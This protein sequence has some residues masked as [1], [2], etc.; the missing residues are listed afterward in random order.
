MRFLFVL[1][2]LCLYALLLIC[3]VFSSSVCRAEQKANVQIIPE[4][5][6]LAATNEN[7]RLKTGT[8]HF[9]RRIQNPKPTVSPRR[10]LSMTSIQTAGVELK[11]GGGNIL[12]GL[13][14]NRRIRNEFEKAKFEIPA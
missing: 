10:I 1:K 14:E 9:A 8:R 4:P 5:K 6:L 2:K 13:L 12:I 11:I 3:A 7:F